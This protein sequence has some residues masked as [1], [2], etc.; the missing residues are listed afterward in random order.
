V[1][2]L[3]FYKFQDAFPPAAEY[4][5]K[6]RELEIEFIT[7]LEAH[8]LRDRGEVKMVQPHAITVDPHF[9]EAQKIKDM[10]GAIVT[11]EEAVCIHASAK[12]HD[13]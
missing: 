10:T 4:I 6:G 8:R 2:H 7:E 1:L 3:E 13:L 5:E 11:P 9:V 12:E